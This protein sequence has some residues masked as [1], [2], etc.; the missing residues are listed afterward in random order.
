VPRRRSAVA[1]EAGTRD[2]RVT[3]AEAEQ[4]LAQ[5]ARGEDSDGTAVN[6]LI[7]EYYDA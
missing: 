3:Y 7:S 2:G 6:D 4:F 5:V 1:A